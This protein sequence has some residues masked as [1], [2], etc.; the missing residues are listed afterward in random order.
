[1]FLFQIFLIVSLVLY[2]EVTIKDSKYAG[3]LNKKC[4]QMDLASLRI[5]IEENLL[6]FNVT[7]L[8]LFY[9]YK[10]CS[11]CDFVLLKSFAISDLPNSIIIDSNY[12]YY[13]TLN[14]L[15]KNS[16]KRQLCNYTAY[17]DFGE[18]GEYL[19]QINSNSSCFIQNIK[20]PNDPIRTLFSGIAAVI[21]V[22]I[23][24]NLIE[25]FLKTNKHA[26]S[27]NKRLNS[28]DAFRG[29]S[30]FLMIFFNYGAGGY[31]F[32]QHADWH[33]LHMAGNLKQLQY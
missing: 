15:F 4:N 27:Y 17:E 22:I 14:V 20:K 2:P 28:L 21:L 7:N 24:W 25:N 23:C 32:L 31:K 29:F 33:G 10:M 11:S 30:L 1:M 12:G 5:N 8:E 13:F 26:K 16:T 3:N 9:Q 18:C 6:M 19:L